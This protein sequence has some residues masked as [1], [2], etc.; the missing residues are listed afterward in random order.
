MSV[1]ERI[2]E[3]IA[4]ENIS[5]R[6]FCQTIGVSPTYV[7]SIRKSILPDKLDSIAMHFPNLNTDWLITGRG[8]M[9]QDKI[10]VVDAGDGEKLVDFLMSQNKTQLHIIEDQ[11]YSIR[12][13]QDTI[14]Q[15]HTKM[16]EFKLEH[17]HA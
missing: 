6:Q 15:L 5:I 1:K 11:A 14:E 12:K 7:N 10:G 8:D 3:F 4:A 17:N 16:K 13:M 9:Y 2:K